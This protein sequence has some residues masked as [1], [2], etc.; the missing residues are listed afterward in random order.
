MYDKLIKHISNYI[1]IEDKDIQ[2]L[3]E[4]IIYHDLKN[5]Q[6]ILEEGQVC[7]S[8]YFVESGCLRM[9]FN[10]NKGVEQTTQFALEN[11]W[12]TDIQ[13][14]LNQMPSDYYIQAIEKSKII[15]INHSRFKELLSEVPVFETY[16]R[17]ITEIALSASQLRIK[18]LYELSKEEMYI[19]FRNSFPE[20]VQR[21]P[22][23]MLASFLGLT[24][25]YLSEI[26]KK[27]L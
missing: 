17:I 27:N 12:M 18:L 4:Y 25:E 5:K 16:F 14:I 22:Q 19:H 11:W 1:N 9:F 20:F 24:P 8:Y 2:K 3:S 26:R 7:K 23:Y 10:N 21:V 6:Y 15:S 13:S